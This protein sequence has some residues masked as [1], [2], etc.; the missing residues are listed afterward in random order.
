M[1]EQGDGR[2]GPDMEIYGKGGGQQRSGCV[3]AGLATE[4]ASLA[5]RSDEDAIGAVIGTGPD[6]QQT[7]QTALR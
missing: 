4:L 7:G 3:I 2:S 1:R 6:N 5:N